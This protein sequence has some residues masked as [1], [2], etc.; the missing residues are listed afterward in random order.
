MHVVAPTLVGR[1]DWLATAED[2]AHRQAEVRAFDAEWLLADRAEVDGEAGDADP[3]QAVEDALRHFP[4]DEIL[5]AGGAADPDLEVAL[6]RF[7][8]SRSTHPDGAWG[9]R[10][11]RAYRALRELAAGRNN[12]TPFVLFIGVNTALLLLGLALSLLVLL[13]LWLIGSL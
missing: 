12:A 7:S 2:D 10:H 13:I 3:I 5:I 1:L 4:A 8:A 11:S 9:R 6:R